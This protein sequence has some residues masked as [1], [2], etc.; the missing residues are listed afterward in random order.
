M[1]PLNYVTTIIE[2]SLDV[3]RVDGTC[4]MW[5]TIMLAITTG[6]TDALQ[7]TLLKKNIRKNKCIQS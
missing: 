3:F 6:R 1:H 7:V 4:K 5:V 2:Y